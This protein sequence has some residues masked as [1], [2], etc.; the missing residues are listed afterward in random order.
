MEKV[1]IIHDPKI[2]SIAYSD[3]NDLYIYY[4]LFKNGV[5]KLHSIYVFNKNGKNG[6]TYKRGEIY[7]FQ[8]KNGITNYETGEINEPYIPDVV[9]ETASNCLSGFLMDLFNKTI[10]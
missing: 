1:E 2:I 10:G 6:V 3:K 4:F 9:L 7:H 8:F 5:K